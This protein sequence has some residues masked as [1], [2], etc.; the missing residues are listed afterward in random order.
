MR[1]RIEPLQ[2]EGVVGRGDVAQRRRDRLDPRAMLE[3]VAQLVVELGMAGQP[4][5]TIRDHAG[6][7]FFEVDRDH[8]IKPIFPIPRRPCVSA[9]HSPRFNRSWRFCKP[10]RKSP[11]TD[12]SDRPIRAATSASESPW[13]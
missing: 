1:G 2:G 6:I 12:A 11:A 9:H 4:G 7:E 3:E 5:P 8:L 13:R 10:R